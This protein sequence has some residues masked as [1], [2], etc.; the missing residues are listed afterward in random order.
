VPTCVTTLKA[1]EVNHAINEHYPNVGAMEATALARL[2]HNGPA[3]AAHPTAVAINIVATKS[4]QAVKFT[5][6][7]TGNLDANVAKAALK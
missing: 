3:N 2:Q 7:C 4:S 1:S 6:T 5:I